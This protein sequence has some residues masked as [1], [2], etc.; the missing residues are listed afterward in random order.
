M[1][2]SLPNVFM[3][4]DES[5]PPSGG[6]NNPFCPKSKV[7]A[8]QSER[9]FSM[10]LV[11]SP[12]CIAYIKN[13][14]SA[15]PPSDD[16]CN[17]KSILS[18]SSNAATAHTTASRKHDLSISIV[19]QS[20]KR[21]TLL[22]RDHVN[23]SYY[24]PCLPPAAEPQDGTFV[25][26]EVCTYY[27][28][29]EESVLDT[30]NIN[31]GTQGQQE[32]N[33]LSNPLFPYTTD[34]KWT[35]SLLKILSDMNAPDYAFGQIMKWA[36]AAKIDDYSFSPQGGHSRSQCVTSMYQSFSQSS[37]LLP[38]VVPVISPNN[39]QHGLA[40]S[41][42]VIVFDFVPQLLSLLQNRK[43]MT[44]ENLLIDIN[45]PLRPYDSP[46]IGEAISGSVYKSAYTHFISDPS[47]QLFLPII[48]WIDRTT[49]TG[50]ERFS[51]KPYMFTP[52][53]FKES[54][55]RTIQAWGY[56][57]F[58]PKGKKS[59]AQN[60]RNRPGDN[61]RNYHA[62]LGTVLETFKTSA[63]RLQGVSL[64]LG[65]SGSIVVDI[66]PCILFIIQDMQEGDM[67][68]GR[69][70]PHTPAIRRHCRACN[71]SYESL[72]DPMVSCKYLYAA[73]MAQIALHG[74][75]ET[76]T[77]WSQHLLDNAFSQIPFADP[78]RG[79]LGA[80]P[81]ETMHAF[82]KGMIEMVTFLVLDNIPT[83]K[84]AALDALATTFHQRHRQT[85]R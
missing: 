73:P 77:M 84:K 11:R 27:D 1:K 75:L 66:V 21:P 9:A 2:K 83:R 72:D 52:A 81:V 33:D 30:T 12:S 3:A 19:S 46:V 62:Q 48:Q 8:F 36:H 26:N 54:F 43:I 29:N 28:A 67:L 47:Q 82:R 60:R 23:T 71:V 14:L 42:D 74:D 68:C 44:A 41:C 55:R 53:I 22:R 25:N 59:S 24:Y 58:L 17:N 4:Q 7:G 20:N 50:N 34:Q 78:D 37:L 31:V 69:F 40:V 79:I 18:S 10:H 32:G 15:N 49:V 35:V 38:T 65:P 76:R 51:L 6:C 5:L 80:T 57:G 63:N 64:P 39:S 13:V 85:H 70:G 61:I 56:H 16:R 45:D